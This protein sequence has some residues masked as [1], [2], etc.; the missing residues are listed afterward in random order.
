MSLYLKYRPQDFGSMVGQQHAIQTLR[1]ALIQNNLAHAYLF[2]GSRGTGK[3]SLARIV[4]KALNC[5]AR[6]SDGEPCHACEMCQ[7]AAQGRL[8]DLIEIDAASN[9]GIDEIRDLREK[10]LFSPSQAKAKVYIIDEVHM[11]TKEAFNAL[12][13]TLEEPPDHA[14]FILATT[15]FHK[16]PETIVSRCQQFVFRRIELEDIARRLGE[17]A[18]KEGISA[19][20][21]ALRLIAKAANGGLRDAIGLLEQMASAQEGSLVAS[22]VAKRL[23]I[24]G[25]SSLESFAAA[26]SQSQAAQAIELLN[27]IYS[28]G[29]SLSQFCAQWLE[30][31]RGKMLACLDEPQKLSRLL[32]WIEIFTQAKHQLSQATLPQLPL[33]IAAV[34][35]C[36]F[37]SAAKGVRPAPAPAQ[38]LQAEA[39][40]APKL[41]IQPA[42]APISVPAPD[43]PPAAQPAP[44]LA[45]LSLQRIQEG[46][47]EMLESIGTPFLKM[48]LMD[49]LPC[50]YEDGALRIE[51]NS[52][53]LMGKVESPIQHQEVLEAFGKFFGAKPL[54]KLSVRKIPLSSEASAPAPSSP[55]QMAQEVF[56]ME[57]GN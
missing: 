53:T 40:P 41:P 14:Y 57:A 13:K 52:S 2:C 6:K 26:L 3:T 25:E 30:Y 5:L 4:A 51:F 32:E 1:N 44:P 24:S 23:G 55:M 20:G 21:E 35:A 36:H 11:L 42:P 22:Q 9:R 29:Q 18:G 27:Q 43:A 31:L 49:G 56:G 10:I 54:L 34:K 12:L 17:I 8:V 48:A 28:E 47:R 46:W 45:P 33:E 15:E 39:A 16:I 50:A 38:S 7:A 37:G 19:E